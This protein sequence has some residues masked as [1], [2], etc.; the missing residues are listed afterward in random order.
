MSAVA[1]NGYLLGQWPDKGWWHYYPVTILVK[2]PIPLLLLM[3]S[4]V[5][6]ALRRARSL[7]FAK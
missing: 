6:L 2:T 1:T 7:T 5:V 3:G 4:S